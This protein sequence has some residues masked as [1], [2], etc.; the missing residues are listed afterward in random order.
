[1]KLDG[2][3]RIAVMMGGPGKERDVSLASGRAVVKALQEKGFQVVGVDVEDTIP[4]LPEGT[5]LAFNLIHGTF[6]EDGGLQRY[7][8]GLGV[9]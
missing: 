8:E 9:R 3:T 2:A 1:M 6:G 5:D 7:L 4:V